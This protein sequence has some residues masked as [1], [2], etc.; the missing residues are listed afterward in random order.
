[1]EALLQFR[2]AIAQ[3]KDRPLFKIIRNKSL[4]QLAVIKPKSMAHLEKSGTLSPKQIHM[5]GQEI[6]SAIT[7]ASGLADRDLPEY[8]RKKAP[9]VPAR[10]GTSI[11]SL[12]V[13][14]DRQARA[15]KIDP[16][17][18]CTNVQISL[19]ALQNPRNLSRLARIKELKKWQIEAF[20]KD[21]VEVLKSANR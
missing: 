17:L 12:R 21:I 15:L 16:S 6:I 10:V 2:K 20:G 1:M 19:I 8:P 14:R 9:H 11:K 18:I 3:K 4:L 13:W 7:S 5:Y